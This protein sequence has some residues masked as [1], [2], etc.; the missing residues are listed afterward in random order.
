VFGVAHFVIYSMAAE[1]YGPEEARRFM[2]RYYGF[3]EA[4][5]GSPQESP[6]GESWL[7]ALSRRV[8]AMFAASVAAVQR[9]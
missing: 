5:A 8:S 3:A 4:N 2:P 6:D 1:I 9:L 7:A